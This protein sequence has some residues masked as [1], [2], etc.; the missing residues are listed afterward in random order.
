MLKY[1]LYIADSD[2]ELNKE[3][4]ELGLLSPIREEAPSKGN[5]CKQDRRQTDPGSYMNEHC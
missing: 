3:D 4:S 2:D 5:V 1:Q